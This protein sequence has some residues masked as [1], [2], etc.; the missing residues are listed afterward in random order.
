MAPLWDRIGTLTMPVTIVVGG[1]DAKFID[2]AERYAQL[3]PQAEV[4][5]TDGAGHGVPREAPREL[6]ALIAGAGE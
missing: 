3:L 2:Y 6:A 5:T 4:H 1:R